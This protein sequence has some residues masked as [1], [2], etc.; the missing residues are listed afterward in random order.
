M[1]SQFDFKCYYLGLYHLTDVYVSVH[2]IADRVYRDTI[3]L[4]NHLYYNTFFYLELCCLIITISFSYEKR[5]QVKDT[6]CIQTRAAVNC[7]F[8]IELVKHEPTK[9]IG[10]KRRDPLEA[11]KK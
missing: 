10:S 8:P 5:T 4:Y 3:K 2:Q 7:V 11:R 9:Q 1:L 6:L